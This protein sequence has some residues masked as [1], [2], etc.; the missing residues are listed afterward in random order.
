MNISRENLSDL[1]LLIKVEIGE[2][3]YAEEVKKQLKNYKN[4][5]MVPGF[6][7]GM[8]PMGLIERMYKGAIVADAVQ[9]KLTSSLYDYLENSW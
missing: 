3:D 5:A 2:S 9:N 8:A 7:K 6:R 1:D 4:K